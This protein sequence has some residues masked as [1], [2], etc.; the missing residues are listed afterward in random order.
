MRHLSHV[1]FMVALTACAQDQLCG[2]TQKLP[3][4]E[5]P[6]VI[7]LAPSRQNIEAMKRHG[8]LEDTI[9]MMV[10]E[11]YVC[12]TIGHRWIA[13]CGKSGCT[14]Q[15]GELTRHCCVCYQTEDEPKGG[16]Q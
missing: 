9:K 2:V 5:R 3:T 7:P 14:E 10:A 6:V 12:S 4:T 16:A 8:T 13:G 11:G 1:L 15:H